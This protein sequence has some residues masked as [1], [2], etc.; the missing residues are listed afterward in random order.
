MSTLLQLVQD[1][2]NRM[3]A[4]KRKGTISPLTPGASS[5]SASPFRNLVENNFQPKYFL[6]RSW[7]NFCEEHHKETTCEVK[8]SVRDKIFGKIPEATIVVLEFAEPDNIMVINTRNKAY[9]SKVKFDPP[10]SSSIPSSCSTAT[11]LQVPKVPE[12]QGITPCPPSSNYNILNQLVNIKA[13]AT[14]LHMVSIPEQQMHLKQFM[15]GKY[16]VVANIFEE[17]N[18]DDSSV[19]KV[20]LHKFRYPVKIP[21]L[22]IYVNIMDKISHC[23]IID[24]GSG[25]SVMSKI[26]LEDLGLS[27]TNENAISMISYNSLQQ[28]TIRKIKDV[29]LVLFAH[30]DIRTTLNIQVIHMPVRNYSIIL[31]RDW[32]ALIDGY[33]SLDET[34]LSIPRN[35]KNIISLREGI[36]SPYIE[37]VLQSSV[38]YIE[39]DLGVY[40]IFV[41]EDNIPLEKNDLDDDI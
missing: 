15:E 18:E 5:S 28:T 25:P 9:T 41:E 37:S 29:T 13:D 35:G 4:F 30:P 24:G 1:M 7:C 34:H 32:Q 10:H 17:V 39:E 33:L 22:Y 8:K 26:I 11:M 19:N 12:I 27:C 21:P 14:L 36:I 31:W 3:I 23:C 6:P 16:F 2:N 20:G 38:N 40:S